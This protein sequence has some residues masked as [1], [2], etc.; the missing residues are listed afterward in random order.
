VSSDRKPSVL[1][2]LATAN[3]RGAEIQ[4]L[5]LS[6]ELAA[7][8]LEV[9]VIALEPASAA[10]AID[11]EV[12]GRR[13][14]DIRGWIRL[15][16]RAARADVVIGYGSTTL[17]AL[18]IALAGIRTVR[19]YR[20]IGD[21]T[22]WAGGPVRR[23]R[24]R[25]LMS[26][27]Q[28]VVVLWP[29]AADSMT[30]LYGVPDAQLSVIPN[31]RHG[32]DHRPPTLPERVAAR[33]ALGVDDTALVVAMVGALAPEK[34]VDL[35]IRSVAALDN[36]ML[37]VA[38]S[39]PFEQRLRELAQSLLP[40]RSS[41]LGSIDDVQVVYRAADVLLLTSHTEGM[42]GT[43]I[44]AA[45]SGVPVVATDVGGTRSLF[46]RGV[47]GFLVA[48]DAS[49]TEIARRISQCERLTTNGR[50]LVEDLT[51]PAVSTQWQ[52]LVLTALATDGTDRRTWLDGCRSRHRTQ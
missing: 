41:F 13:R 38:G 19:I 47:S 11:V 32:D 9:D 36:A 49:P 3:R 28:R 34:R 21:P 18:A 1:L 29:K 27:M 50:Q 8:G 12:M 22:A 20:S 2:V 14:H 33:T 51:W 37:I 44:E 35:G 42:P 30:S 40:G 15:R 7:H 26:R 39:G 43:A 10:N 17:P 46:E 45:L 6:R 52:D 31:A 48:K 24:T 25:L 23:L 4:G 5:Q 16:A